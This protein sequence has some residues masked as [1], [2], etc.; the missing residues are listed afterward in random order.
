MGAIAHDVIRIQQMFLLQGHGNFPPH[1]FQRSTAYWPG[2]S[3]TWC[4][5]TARSVSAR[6]RSINSWSAR[7]TFL[8]QPP[9]LESSAFDDPLRQRSIMAPTSNRK[10]FSAELAFR[11]PSPAPSAF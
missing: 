8:H 5:L 4:S 7:N 10:K 3:L 6:T 11:L 9:E 2:V 1:R